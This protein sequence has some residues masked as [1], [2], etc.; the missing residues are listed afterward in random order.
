MAATGACAGFGAIWGSSLATAATMAQVALPEPRSHGYSGR[1]STGTLA[2]AGTLGILILP[3]VPLAIYAVL[4]QESIGKLF[5]AAVISGVTMLGYMLVIRV[6]VTLGPQAGPASEC[7]SWDER[8]KVTVTVSVLPAVGVFVIVIVGIYGGWAT[9]TEAASIGAAACGILTVTTGGMRWTG[10]RASLIGTAH[11]TAMI[12]L[13]L[14][15]ADL[16]NSGLTL[17]QLP[18]ENSRV[19]SGAAACRRCWC[20]SRCCWCTCCSAA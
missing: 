4:T 11:T 8:L 15:G 18:P 16:L 19:G 2:A 14:L 12:Y 3:S 13:V 1:L 17:T 20:C 5:V 7:H 10:I 6:L 9:P